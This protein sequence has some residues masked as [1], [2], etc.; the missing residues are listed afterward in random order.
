MELVCHQQ[1]ISY[2]R[3]TLPIKFPSG[4]LVREHMKDYMDECGDLNWLENTWSQ[5]KFAV[6]NKPSLL[7]WDSFKVHLTDEVLEK[8]R[9]LNAKLAIIPGGLTSMLQP[10]DVCINKSFKVRLRSKWMEWME[11]EVKAVTKD[12]M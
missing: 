3:K 7:F 2:K 10:L 6:F 11:T 5:R 1:L 9:K 12:A 4:V 8:S